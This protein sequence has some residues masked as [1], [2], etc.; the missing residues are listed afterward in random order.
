MSH[1][2]FNQYAKYLAL[3]IIM[4][5][6]IAM[7]VA[8]PHEKTS[9]SRGW[10]ER[11]IYSPESISDITGHV[12]SD[13]SVLPFHKT[14][15]ATFGLG[16]DA[17][18]QTITWN[19]GDFTGLNVPDPKENYQRGINNSWY[20]STAVQMY[21][22][23]AGIQVHTYSAPSHPDSNL[24]NAQISYQWSESDNEHPWNYDSSIM[25]MRFNL[26]VPTVWVEGGAVAY[27]NAIL[28]LEDTST[29][30]KVWYIVNMYDTRDMSIFKE[31]IGW[32]SG[33]NIPMIITY[34]GHGT[35]YTYIPSNSATSTDKTWSDWK[36]FEF[37]VSRN[38]LTWAVNDVNSQYSMGLSTDPNN[39]IILLMTIQGEIYWPSGGN[40]HL[41][42]SMGDIYL[43][44]VY[45]AVPELT[46]M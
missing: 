14:I 6:P 44:E 17:T 43:S 23:Y 37:F 16:A 19:V 42:V 35:R 11:L 41:G 40:G 39:Y 5:L 34:F 15:M 9:N 32:D 25:A 45:E 33:T 21:G 24:A 3:A 38:N 31:Y 18:S 1:A 12:Y 7:G 2:L 10:E 20:G 4:L 46:L 28:L 30:K 29:G 22:N 8:M 26:Q 36:F 27:S 13:P